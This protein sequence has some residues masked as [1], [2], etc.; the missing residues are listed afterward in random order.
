MQKTVQYI[1]DRQT[2]TQFDPVKLEK[3]ERE[4]ARLQE[5]SN[6]GEGIKWETIEEFEK[7]YKIVLSR[8]NKV[9]GELHS[10]KNQGESGY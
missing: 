1:G 9:Y 3:L 8:I 7:Q 10:K 6:G 4:I 2:K 5:K